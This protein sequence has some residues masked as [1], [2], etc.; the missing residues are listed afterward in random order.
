[1]LISK[2][3]ASFAADL[4]AAGAVYHNQITQWIAAAGSNVSQHVLEGWWQRTIAYQQRFAARGAVAMISGVVPAAIT[5]ELQAIANDPALNV[6][7][8]AAAHTNAVTAIRNQLVTLLNDPAKKP[9]YT[10]A[11]ARTEVVY[12]PSELSGLVS[13]L[14]AAAAGFIRY[15]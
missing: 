14:Q 7:A 13:L 2:P 5:A 15:G 11:G 10:A 3:A 1:M 6:G 12:T 9:G 4:A 8:K